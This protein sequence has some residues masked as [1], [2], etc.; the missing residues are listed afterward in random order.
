MESDLS[1]IYQDYIACLNKQDWQNCFSCHNTTGWKP[2]KWTHTQ[3]AVAGK[4]ASCHNGGYPPADGRSA[5]HI[6]FQ[7]VA[8]TASANCDT[9][10]KSGFAEPVIAQGVDENGAG[11]LRC[12]LDRVPRL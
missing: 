5:T 7:S 11:S 9:C 2:S 1:I 6:P 10:H 8:A 4:C 12:G 3:L